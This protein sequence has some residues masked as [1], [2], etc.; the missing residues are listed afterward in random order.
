MVLRPNVVTM[1]PDSSVTLYAGG[2]S[3]GT[4]ASVCG[5]TLA[6]MTHPR[7]TEVTYSSLEEKDRW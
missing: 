7:F 1:V 6:A 2:I 3:E 4:R 5:E